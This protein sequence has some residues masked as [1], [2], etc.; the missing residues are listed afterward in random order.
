MSE[1]LTEE[2]QRGET[3]VGLTDKLFAILS[4]GGK[5]ALQT[6]S[7]R[8]AALLGVLVL[9]SMLHALGELDGGALSALCDYATLLSVSGVVYSVL[10]SL[11][12]MAGEALS[13]LTA[14]LAALLP[15][16]SAV[17]VSGGTPTA[18]AASA[19]AFSL[20]LSCVELLS[21]QVLFPF[22]QVS[23]ALCFAGALPGA[24]DLSPLSSLVKNTAAVLL[25]FLYTALGFLVGMQS[26]VSAEAD[27]FF[28]RTIRFASGV[29]IPVVGGMLGEAART[30]AGGIGVIR[31][32]VGTVGVVVTLALLLPPLLVVIAH[33][34]LLSLSA[35]LAKMLGCSREAA[36]LTDLG[37]VLG[38]LFGTLAGA[39]A[40]AI[41][42]LAC[43]IKT[44]A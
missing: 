32:T 35:A 20:F 40:V 12:T 11:F 4:S 42:Y 17:L 29:F 27:T 31:G 22:L 19:A 30:V 9:S 33:R 16:T 2:E 3:P 7:S 28:Y 43:F 10:G 41:L 18:A 26:A 37:G 15:V 34:F 21:S 14:Y 5:T 38:L 44:R 24:V 25:A 13:G 23:F 36:L 39:E 1:W 6:A 8:L